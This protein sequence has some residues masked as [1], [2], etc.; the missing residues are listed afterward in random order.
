MSFIEQFRYITFALEWLNL[1]QIEFTDRNMG[2]IH[3]LINVGNSAST[4][5]IDGV[6]RNES[7]AWFSTDRIPSKSFGQ[8]LNMWSGPALGR[9]M[10][11]WWEQRQNKFTHLLAIYLFESH[12]LV[13]ELN[14]SD[15][16]R[17]SA[18]E[19]FAN[20]AKST[21]DLAIGM[22]VINEVYLPL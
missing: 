10:L 22:E 2:H 8:K 1:C 9:K 20:Q 12:L 6:I 21:Y 11:T 15:A 4:L 16:C 18:I 3:E 13:I 7:I 17:F 19:W 5:P 14:E